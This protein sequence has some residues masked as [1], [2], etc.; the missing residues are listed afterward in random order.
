MAILEKTLDP[1]LR[2]L[3]LPN[4]VIIRFGTGID[5]SKKPHSATGS[6]PTIVHGIYI[7]DPKH[8]TVI[9]SI[10][11]ITTIQERITQIER[12]WSG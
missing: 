12:T 8:G 4:G 11:D 2:K 5:T 7:E 1:K 9:L 10:K 6:Y 3:S